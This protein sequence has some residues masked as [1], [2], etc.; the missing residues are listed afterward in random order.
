MPQT[1]DQ[2]KPKKNARKKSKFTLLQIMGLIIFGGLI[3][4]VGHNY[5]VSFL[6]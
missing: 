3:L 2:N 4:I 6:R 1:N 5:Q